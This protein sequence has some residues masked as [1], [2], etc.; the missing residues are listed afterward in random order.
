VDATV[1][2][3]FATTHGMSVATSGTAAL[4]ASPTPPP[5]RTNLAKEP[6]ALRPAGRASAEI[7]AGVSNLCITRSPSGGR[8]PVPGGSNVR[9]AR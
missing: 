1:I 5:N 9:R 7:G 2:S 4:E 8:Q 6:N 3:A